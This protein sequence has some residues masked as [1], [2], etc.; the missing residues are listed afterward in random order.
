MYWNLVL[1]ST[2]GISGW[3][4]DKKKPSVFTDGFDTKFKFKK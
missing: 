4:S 3:V 1:R 2:L